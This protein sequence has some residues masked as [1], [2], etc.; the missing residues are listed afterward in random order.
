MALTPIARGLVTGAIGKLLLTVS[1]YQQL[2]SAAHCDPLAWVLVD[3]K[4]ET[5][6]MQGNRIVRSPRATADIPQLILLDN[7]R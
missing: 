4:E 2:S 6:G 1:V 5:L 3:G 7:V